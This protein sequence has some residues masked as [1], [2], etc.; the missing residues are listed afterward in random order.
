MEIE[1]DSTEKEKMQI[2]VTSDVKDKYGDYILCEDDPEEYEDFSIKTMVKQEQ[3]DDK[4]IGFIKNQQK[5]GKCKDHAINVFITNINND[6]DK[7]FQAVDVDIPEDKRDSFMMVDA[8]T[9]VKT[10]IKNKIEGI[11]AVI[12]DI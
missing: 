3:T 1:V 12:K 10:H 4:L 9:G 11:K 5:V 8:E 7:E 6:I 2:M